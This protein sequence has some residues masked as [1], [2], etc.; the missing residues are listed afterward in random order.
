MQDNLDVLKTEIQDYLDHSGFTTF[1]GH[2]RAYDEDRLVCGTLK[3]RPITR[4]F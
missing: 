3:N 2:S 4:L 1:P